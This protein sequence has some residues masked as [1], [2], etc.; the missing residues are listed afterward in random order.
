MRVVQHST[1]NHVASPPPG[2]THEECF[3]MPVTLV[4]Y[5]DGATGILSYWELDKEDLKKLNAGGKIRLS[6][7]GQILPPVLLEVETE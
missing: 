6:I 4:K 1:N 2:M 3:A 7:L 5:S